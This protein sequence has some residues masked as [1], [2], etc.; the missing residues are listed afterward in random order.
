MQTVNARVGMRISI[1]KSAKE[2]SKVL[3]ARELRKKATQAEQAPWQY[4]R[5]RNFFGKKFRRQ[6]VFR[7]FVL[8]F[9]CPEDKL[10]IE[11]DGP[12]HLKQKEYD[13]S[14]EHIIGD[15]GVKLLRSQNRKVLADTR[16]VLRTIKKNLTLL[17]L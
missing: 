11:L 15:H 12:I 10:A 9:Y 17:H 6:Y 16:E 7:G 14:R 1:M 3:R 5:D 2:F 4:L 13:R 8:D